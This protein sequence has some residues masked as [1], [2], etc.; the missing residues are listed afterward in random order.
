MKI[1]HDKGWVTFVMK[2]GN[3]FVR[4]KMPLSRAN[5]IVKK[6]KNVI[7]TDERGFGKE[8]LVNDEIFF[9]IEEVEVT[10]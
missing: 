8:I 6:S 9:P 7:E 5:A 4:N 1:K 2:T 10:K 3:T